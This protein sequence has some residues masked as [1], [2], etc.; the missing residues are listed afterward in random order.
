MKRLFV[1]VAIVSAFALV[2]T[3]ADAA[4]KRSRGKSKGTAAVETVAPSEP[5]AND[6]RSNNDLCNGGMMITADDQI[7]GCTGLLRMRLTKDAKA[8]ALYNRGNAYVARNDFGRAI[9]DYTDALTF[10]ADYSPALFNRAVAHR[11]TGNAQAAI[12]DYT[13]ALAIT[14]ADADAFAGRGIARASL[15]KHS[16]ALDD[17][18]RAIEIKPNHLLALTNRGH[19]YVRAHRWALAIADYSAAIAISTASVDA[20]YGRGVAKVYNGDM[21]SGQTDMTQALM[22]DSGV[23]ARMTS[24]GIPPPAI[25]AGS[26]F[27]PATATPQQPPTIALPAPPQPAAPAAADPAV[28]NVAQPAAAAAPVESS[29]AEKPAEKPK[30]STWQM[31]PIP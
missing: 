26:G 9:A 23:T 5:T 18:S 17:F 3:D 27:Q 2:T 30:P 31:K 15:A 28:T 11:V 13:A 20:I 8:T 22:I 6:K 7:R 16:E 25:T 14:P 4:K 12:N 10:R 21:L 24:L 1:L 29:P 19:A